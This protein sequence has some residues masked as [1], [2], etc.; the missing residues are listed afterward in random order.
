MQ[1]KLVVVHN[2]PGGWEEH[3]GEGVWS[4]QVVNE[5]P[6]EGLTAGRLLMPHWAVVRMTGS[7]S[8]TVVAV[9]VHEGPG[10]VFSFI[11]YSAQYS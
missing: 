9:H 2:P 1:D 6:L 4:L 3:S 5:D 8:D 11:Q 10:T 7:S